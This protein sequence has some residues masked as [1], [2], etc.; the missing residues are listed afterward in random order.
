MPHAF[1]PATVDAIQSFKQFDESACGVLS[2]AQF[3][4]LTRDLNW[5]DI[6]AWRVA[7]VLSDEGGN[8]SLRAFVA[9]FNDQQLV[10]ELL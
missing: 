4:E 6:E 7:R 3:L 5:L 8:V 1:L 9:L 2:R 10:H